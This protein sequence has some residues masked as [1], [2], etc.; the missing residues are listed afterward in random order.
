MSSSTSLVYFNK[1]TTDRSIFGSSPVTRTLARWAVSLFFKTPRRRLAKLGFGAAPDRVV[2]IEGNQVAIHD[3]G[4]GPV[5]LLV[6]GW[7]GAA[8]QWDHLAT[9]LLDSGHRVVALDLPGH[10]HS[11]GSDTN[12]G[13]IARTLLAVGRRVGPLHAVVAHSLGAPG[14]ARAA[15][16]GLD[17]D[18]LVFV[19]A[20]ASPSEYWSMFK[21][22]L[23]LPKAVARVADRILQ[24]RARLA[25]P[26]LEMA[27]N[28]GTVVAPTLFVHDS[29][30]R[31]AKLERVVPV[32]EGI[33]ASLLHTRGLGHSRLLKDSF[34]I[35]Q[36]VGFVQGREVNTAVYDAA[37]ARELELQ[38]ELE[39]ELAEPALRWTANIEAR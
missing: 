10:G 30:D 4:V 26:Q 13:E 27:R 33:G 36:I 20:A 29:R 23:H 5:V 12:L 16:E 3:R 8:S 17:V 24:A 18:R 9:Q 34:V 22:W 7:G 32:A 38:R 35:G 28:L 14:V 15:A 39:A 1:S 31:V 11:S 25:L 21:S 19:A 2:E 6:H 37:M